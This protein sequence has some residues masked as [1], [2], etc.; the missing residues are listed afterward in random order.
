MVKEEIED[1]LVAHTEK[2]FKQ[3]QETPLGK[4]EWQRALGIDCMSAE[5]AAIMM[6]ETDSPLLR[7]V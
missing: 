7:Q 5:A 1:V 6:A 4:G 2:R 3:Y